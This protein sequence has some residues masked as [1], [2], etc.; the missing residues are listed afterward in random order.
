M[1]HKPLR[2]LAAEKARGNKPCNPSQLGDP[3][4]LKAET[5]DREPD[6]AAEAEME[7]EAEPSSPSPYPPSV[8]A[9]GGGGGGKKRDRGKGGDRD[10]I[11]TDL[12]IP[13]AALEG[14]AMA[15]GEEEGVVVGLGSGA[16]PVG[17]VRKGSK[18]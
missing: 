17:G 11:G 15:R 4:D 6:P 13:R 18:L 7:A 10:R 14:D 16:G 1:P 3:I 9:G 5:S 8:V 2:Q 12:K